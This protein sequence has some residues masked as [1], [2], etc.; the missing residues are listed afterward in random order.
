MMEV[1]AEMLRTG[2]QRAAGGPTAACTGP[3]VAVARSRRRALAGG[4][5]RRWA[6]SW[7]A[8]GS[9]A[10]RAGS[11]GVAGE[12]CWAPLGS[13]RRSS[14]PRRCRRREV[15]ARSSK[16]GIGRQKGAVRMH[17]TRVPVSLAGSGMTYLNQVLALGLCD[18][19]LQLGGGKGVDEAGLRHD[20][21][22]DLGARQDGEF[23]GLM[24]PKKA[25]LARLLLGRK[26]QTATD[27]AR[28]TRR[29][30]APP[31]PTMSGLR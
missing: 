21:E 22:Q 29:V 17:A 18:E 15:R 10:S 4:P 7:E 25:G 13:R 8:G 28:Q 26:G 1:D 3:P 9:A 14:R 2:D 6:C 19:R 24:H 31:L 30:V 27:S 23:V 12:R 5:S 20:E 11:A 16:P